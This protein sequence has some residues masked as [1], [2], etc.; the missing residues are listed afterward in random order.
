[1]HVNCP[2]GIVQTRLSRRG[3]AHADLLEPLLQLGPL[4]K[5]HHDTD[6]FRGE[7]HGVTVTPAEE[8]MAQ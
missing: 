5:T 2:R 4:A 1:M 6:I 3:R 8:S 7:L